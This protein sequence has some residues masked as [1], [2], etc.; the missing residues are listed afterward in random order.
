[1]NNE[2]KEELRATVGAH[3]PAIAL[4]SPETRVITEQTVEYASTIGADIATGKP[5]RVLVWRVSKGFEEWALF[6]T[7]Q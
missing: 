5:R 3:I 7:D 1:M 4:S 6:V 2:L